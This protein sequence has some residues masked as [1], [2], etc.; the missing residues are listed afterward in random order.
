[1][2]QPMAEEVTAPNVDREGQAKSAVRTLRLARAS[3]RKRKRKRKRKCRS[4]AQ[5]ESGTVD[6]W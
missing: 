6:T 3:K 1:M 5:P 4:S 2:L